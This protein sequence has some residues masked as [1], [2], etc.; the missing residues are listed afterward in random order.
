MMIVVI[1]LAESKNADPEIVSAMIGGIEAA[2]SKSGHMA[3]RID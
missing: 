2:V 1:A 3:D